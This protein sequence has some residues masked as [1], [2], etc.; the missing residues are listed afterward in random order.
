VPDAG[1]PEEIAERDTLVVTKSFGEP[2]YPAWALHPKNGLHMDGRSCLS[3][4]LE[5]RMT[6]K[7]GFSLFS[8]FKQV[9][10]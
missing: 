1:G 6:P 5:G 9:G 10:G 7:L 2:L 3:P 8:A 4:L